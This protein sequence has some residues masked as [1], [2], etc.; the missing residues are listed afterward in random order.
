MKMKMKMKIMCQ[1]I[2]LLF[3]LASK[4]ELFK[5]KDDVN[6]DYVIMDGASDIS[7]ILRFLTDVSGTK[8]KRK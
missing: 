2:Q 5:I 3:D 6:K 4:L 7:T 8:S 1:S